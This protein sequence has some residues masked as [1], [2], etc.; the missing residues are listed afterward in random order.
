VAVIPG[1]KK[2]A[3]GIGGRWGKGLVTHRGADGKWSTPS[4][5]EMSGASIGFQIGAESSDLVL[6]FSNEEGFRSMMDGKLKLGADASVAA[7]PVGRSAEIGTDAKMNSAIWAYSRSKGLF[8][9]VA[10][11]GAVLEIDDSANEKVYGRKMSGQDILLNHKAK[12]NAVVAP[13]VAAVTKHT[14]NA[15]RISEKQ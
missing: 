10:L 5:I 11:D 9:G 15:R 2:G 14:A 8:A 4:F 7:G 1:V 12:S 6:V 3:F 13:F